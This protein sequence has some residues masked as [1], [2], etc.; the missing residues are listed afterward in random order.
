MG[1]TQ[2]KG[3]PSE[4]CNSIASVVPLVDLF[5]KGMPPIAGGVLDQSAWFIEASRIFNREEAMIRAELK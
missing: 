5:G 3:C 2:L 4:Y 1:T